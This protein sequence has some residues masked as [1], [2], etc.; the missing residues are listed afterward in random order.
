MAIPLELVFRDITPYEEAVEAEV[1]KRAEKLER[2]FP[3]I[4]NCRVVVEKPHKH[5]KGGNIYMVKIDLTVP[6]K[7]L[8]V[9]REHPM[10]K[11]HEDIFVAIRD[12][13]D[14]ARRQ[15][16]E[17]AEVERGDVKA[18]ESVPTGRVSRLYPEE[19]YGFIE[20]FGGREIYFH[21]NSVLDGFEALKVGVEVRFEEEEG[22]KGPQASTVKIVQ[23]PLPPQAKNY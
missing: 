10:R 22:E 4:V 7:K 12:A 5:H 8:V 18:H 2:F 1:R 17:Y 16:E 3:L 14:A 6:E 11:S 9:N 19:G 21:R 20:G 23:K 13:F 15:L